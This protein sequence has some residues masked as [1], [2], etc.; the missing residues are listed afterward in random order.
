LRWHH[1]PRV[2]LQA[3][4][5]ETSLG[6]RRS[7]LGNSRPRCD[8]I[9]VWHP[10]P[11]LLGAPRFHPLPCFCRCTGGCRCVVGISRRTAEYQPTLD[12][13]I[14]LSGNRQPRFVGR[15]DGWWSRGSVLRTL[16]QPSLLSSLESYSSVS[17]WSRA[18][19]HQPRVY[20]HPKRA[21]LDLGSRRNA[22][23]FGLVISLAPSCKGGRTQQTKTNNRTNRTTLAMM[24][25]VCLE[26]DGTSRTERVYRVADD[27]FHR[28]ARIWNAAVPR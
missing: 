17:D 22:G 20:R 24:R 18:I 14:F 27:V 7:V 1:Y 16:R 2:L 21:S 4:H 28:H 5:S 15:H 11:R 10:V 3:R 25:R 8:W 13:D 9:P 12:V 23:C 19:F 26:V 6:R